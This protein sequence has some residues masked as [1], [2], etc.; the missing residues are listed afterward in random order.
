MPRVQES[1]RARENRFDRLAK[2]SAHE[3]GRPRARLGNP[4]TGIPEVVVL[5]VFDVYAAAEGQPMG[6]LVLFTVPQG[7]TFNFNGVTAFIKGPGHT[8]LVQAGMLESSYTFI[9]R[10]LSAYVQGVQ[11]GS[12]GPYA[13]VCDVL[14]F[15]SSYT[16][17]R[18]NKKS[19]FEGILAWLPGGA[20]PTYA[21]AGSTAAVAD[22]QAS[23]TNGWP[24][25][26]NIYTIPGGQYINPQEQFDWI[27][28]PTLNAGGTPSCLAGQ[29]VTAGVPQGGIMAWCRLDGTLIRVAQ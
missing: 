24:I 19:Y 22:L 14:N 20:G 6:K 12:H 28:D 25:A 21:T 18:I 26:T 2:I 1:Y 3:L 8:S 9:V 23:A 27:I 15:T 29:A 7:Q 13:C 16:N 5:P 11:G 4:N 10:G 17:F